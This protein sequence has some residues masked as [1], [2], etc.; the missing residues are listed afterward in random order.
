MKQ[1]VAALIAVAFASVVLAQGA[2]TATPSA[3]AP[4]ASS[5]A[6]AKGQEK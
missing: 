6:P 1:L 2:V 3:K 4:E 5:S